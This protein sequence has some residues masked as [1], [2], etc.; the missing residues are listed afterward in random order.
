MRNFMIYCLQNIVV[1]DE[2]VE[3]EK[4]GNLRGRAIRKTYA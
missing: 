1:G 4:W 2:M 3:D